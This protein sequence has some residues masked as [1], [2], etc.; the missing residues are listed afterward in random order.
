MPAPGYEFRRFWK[1]WSPIIIVVAA[2][3]W[4]VATAMAAGAWSVYQFKESTQQ[5]FAKLETDRVEA[6]KSRLAQALEAEKAR[7]AVAAE[8]EKNRT[9]E[10]RARDQ[11]RRWSEDDAAKTRRIEA[12]KPFLEERLKTYL[13]AIRVAS[14]LTQAD[15]PTSSEEWKHSAQTFFQM[16]WG[17]LEMVGDPGIRNAARLIGEQIGRVANEP[18]MDRH[19]LRWSVECLADELRYSLEH[20]WGLEPNAERRTVNQG[21]VLKIPNGCVAGRDP[22]IAPP[23]MMGVGIE[24]GPQSRMQ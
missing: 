5:F 10:Q 16:R 18:T 14:R 21:Y 7:L 17:E 1:Q 3:V 20:T 8:A 2:A 23:G 13:E 4:T 6:E 11:A 22:P 15:L 12:Q 24:P 9:E 19:D